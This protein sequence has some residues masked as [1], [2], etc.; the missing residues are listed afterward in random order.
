MERYVFLNLIDWV[1]SQRR[2][3][4]LLRGARQVG[5]TWLIDKLAREQFEFYLKVDFEENSELGSLF[6]GD[7]NPQKICSELE[8][9]TGIDIIAGKTLLFFDEIQ[10]WPKAIRAY[11][12]STIDSNIGS[13]PIFVYHFYIQS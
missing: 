7:L 1:K 2:K 13:K 10:I 8:L 12:Q 11:A 9:R 3:P 6:D 4:L 5:K